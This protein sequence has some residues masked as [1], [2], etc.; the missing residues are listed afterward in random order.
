MTLSP[1]IERIGFLPS[2]SGTP[3]HSGLNNERPSASRHTISP[4]RMA[5]FTRSSLVRPAR[6]GSKVRYMCPF[7]ETSRQAPFSMYA[8]ARK[9]SSFSSQSHA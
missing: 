7:R 4:S 8:S 1:S 3:S 2:L 6:S 5:S 9:P